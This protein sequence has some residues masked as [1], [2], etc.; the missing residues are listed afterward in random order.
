MRENL[1]HLCNLCGKNY[2]IVRLICSSCGGKSFSDEVAKDVMIVASTKI[3][4]HPGKVLEIP[5]EVQLLKT[6]EGLFL[7]D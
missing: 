6:Q 3:L 1:I 4:R 2:S 7:I 5:L